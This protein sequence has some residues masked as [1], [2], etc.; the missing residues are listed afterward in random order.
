MQKHRYKSFAEFF[1]HFK[2][3]FGALVVALLA[4]SVGILVNRMDV[5]QDIRKQAAG[6]ECEA[7]L[8]PGNVK[9]RSGEEPGTILFSWLTSLYTD[10]YAISYGMESGNYEYGLVNVGTI[11]QVLVQYLEPG[12]TYFFVVAAV[13]ECD[14]SPY[15]FEV[16]AVATAEKRVV[17]RT[18][19]KPT[20]KP[21]PSPSPSPDLVGLL[22]ATDSGEATES[23]GATDSALTIK[24]KV[25][26]EPEKKEEL[27]PW[28]AVPLQIPLLAGL[29]VV[30]FMLVAGVGLMKRRKVPNLPS[31]Q[32]K[33][34]V[35]KDVMVG[36]KSPTPVPTETSPSVG[37]RKEPQVPG[38][39]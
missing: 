29:V 24:P 4:L 35:E 13:N 3:G 37:E 7:P 26:P 28:W 2:V 32:A 34:V 11:R 31:A 27:T 18:T 6:T 17:V 30:I 21:L 23:A 33:K 10:H 16:A 25:I 9:A 15:S 22:D 19:P 5:S 20:V 12:K 8:A 1:D 36:M 38:S 39:Q 14:S